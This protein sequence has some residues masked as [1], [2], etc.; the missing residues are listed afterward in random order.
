MK[1]RVYRTARM[2]AVMFLGEQV[3]QSLSKQVRKVSRTRVVQ[4]GASKHAAVNRAPGGSL[5]RETR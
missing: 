1:Q 3:W 2:A 4:N 5:E